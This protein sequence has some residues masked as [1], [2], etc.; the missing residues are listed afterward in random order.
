MLHPAATMHSRCDPKTCRTLD[1][2]KTNPATNDRN[3]E[4]ILLCGPVRCKHP[5]SFQ[6]QRSRAA[7]LKSQ[8]VSVDWICEKG[9]SLVNYRDRLIEFEQGSFANASQILDERLPERPR[10]LS[11]IRAERAVFVTCL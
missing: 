6:V 2:Y 9:Q 7:C 5:N 11:H 10:V 3:Q 8:I 1:Q 4:A